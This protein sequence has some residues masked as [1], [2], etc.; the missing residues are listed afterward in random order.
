MTY[1]WIR[2]RRKVKVKPILAWRKGS[3]PRLKR[4]R[5]VTRALRTEK[6]YQY[7]QTRIKII[8]R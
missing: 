7:F 1:L 3:G 4:R 8:V 5:E 2:P 6:I